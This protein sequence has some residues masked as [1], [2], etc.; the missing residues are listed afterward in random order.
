MRRQGR[1]TPFAGDS[2]SG[3]RCLGMQQQR[4]LGVGWLYPDTA[5][6]HLVVCWAEVFKQAIRPLADGVACPV[7]PGADDTLLPGAGGGG[8]P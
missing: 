6:L 1:F 7:Q 4:G 3:S 2:D 8:W 5:D